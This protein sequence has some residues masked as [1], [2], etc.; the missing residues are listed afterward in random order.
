M[1]S[2]KSHDKKWNCKIFK[3]I[4]INGRIATT[5]GMLLNERKI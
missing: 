4:E 3:T 2:N 5:E 1:K